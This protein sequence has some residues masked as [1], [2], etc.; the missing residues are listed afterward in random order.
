MVKF[1]VTEKDL[2]QFPEW[3]VEQWALYVP[4]KGYQF[5][6][7]EDEIDDLRMAMLQ[8]NELTKTRARK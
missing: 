1:Q 3:V 6:D 4:G 5:R 2:E 8:V 7:T